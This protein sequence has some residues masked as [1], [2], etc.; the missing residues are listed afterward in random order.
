MQAY[1]MFA[2]ILSHVRLTLRPCKGALALGLLI[3]QPECVSMT[4]AATFVD[5]LGPLSTHSVMHDNVQ[6]S[7]GGSP[8]GQ[9]TEQH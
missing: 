6:G 4:T 7:V 2:S 1:S 3:L 5:A 9:A 8:E